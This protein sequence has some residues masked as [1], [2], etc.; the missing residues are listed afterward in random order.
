MCTTSKPLHAD[1]DVFRFANAR[2]DGDFSTAFD[3][4]TADKAHPSRSVSVWISGIA[5][6]MEALAI[7]QKSYFCYFTIS[8]EFVRTL[9]TLLGLDCAPLDVIRLPLSDTPPGSGHAGIIGLVR[10]NHKPRDIYKPLR[11][12][13]ADEGRKRMSQ[14]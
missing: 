4:S 9:S 5:E 13:L 10:P 8:T 11:S 12:K 6:P 1:A 7:L 3:P 2:N 14:L